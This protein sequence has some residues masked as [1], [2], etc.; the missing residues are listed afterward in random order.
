MDRRLL[1]MLG[2]EIRRCGPVGLNKPGGRTGAK[3]RIP[4]RDVYEPYLIQEGYLLRN[5]QRAGRPRRWPIDTSDLPRR[6]ESRGRLLL[7]SRGTVT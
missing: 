5:P 1:S 4:S 2:G 3:S 6:K 7:T